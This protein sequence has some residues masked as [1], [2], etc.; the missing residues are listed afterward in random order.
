MPASTWWLG[1]HGEPPSQREV[2]EHAGMDAVTA[3][4]VA[5]AVEAEQLITREQEQ[6]DIRMPSCASKP[7]A[8]RTSG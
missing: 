1:R 2:A 6:H 5:R 3:S 8:V 4:Q 7:S